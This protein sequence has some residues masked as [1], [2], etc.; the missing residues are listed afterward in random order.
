MENTTDIDK[1]KY[2]SA[3][4]LSIDNHLKTLDNRNYAYSIKQSLNLL[5]KSFDKFTKQLYKGMT[6]DQI[7]VYDDW[8]NSIADI[9]D[10]SDKIGVK[11]S[12]LLLEAFINKEFI[13]VDESNPAVKN[14]LRYL[15]NFKK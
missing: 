7:D 1:L 6:N 8:A 12:A 13:E 15:E 3:L 2:I 5:K 11:K 4:F 9:I 14:Q 10:S